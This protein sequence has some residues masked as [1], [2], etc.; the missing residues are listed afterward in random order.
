MSQNK[1]EFQNE[2]RGGLKEED[3][4]Q[5]KST[6][7]RSSS[8]PLPPSMESEDI[9]CFS[10]L[11][12]QGR[13]ADVNEISEGLLQFKLSRYRRVC[14]SF[15]VL[16][17]LIDLTTATFVVPIFPR[18]LDPIS[19]MAIGVLL[20]SKSIMQMIFNPIAATV[21]SHTSSQTSVLSGLSLLS[22]TLL[23][24]SLTNSFYS[25]LFAR[26][27]HGVAASLISNGC[28]SLV[29]Q[30]HPDGEGR[31][32]AMGW[33]MNGIALGI[34]IGPPAGGVAYDI[35]G[36]TLAMLIL[37]SCSLLTMF[38]CASLFF[39]FPY[40]LVDMISRLEILLDSQE[41]SVEKDSL[42]TIDEEISTETKS[43][44]FEEGRSNA[45]S[46]DVDINNR[47]WDNYDSD[48]IPLLSKTLGADSEAD[49][50]VQ[51][52][53]RVSSENDSIVVSSIMVDARG[54]L[55]STWRDMSFLV[56]D[57]YIRVLVIGYG[58]IIL[59]T[60]FRHVSLLYF[61]LLTW[62]PRNYSARSFLSLL[63]LSLNK[64][65]Y[66]Y[67][68]QIYLTIIHLS[69]FV[70]IYGSISSFFTP[71]FKN[72]NTL[73]SQIFDRQHVHGHA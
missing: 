23:I 69:I 30:V 24:Y 29:A 13:I 71:L 3:E 9:L 36:K 57:P 10:S 46:L 33:T 73:S 47:D 41:G 55:L 4:L 19:E 15:T 54:S 18:V 26:S 61:L 35:L 43:T 1:T 64:L 50:P 12:N 65:L 62:K 58:V 49:V 38:I 45:D 44:M 66:I 21:T 31:G 17:L 40:R 53:S 72:S 68:I 2:L 32:L 25:F 42:L 39:G 16:A 52:I 5:M 14:V 67:Y 70:S 37:F 48:P 7:S 20:S 28:F 60:S 6:S 63:L 22:C 27:M 56:G 34:L 11:Q 51:E 59:R 8:S